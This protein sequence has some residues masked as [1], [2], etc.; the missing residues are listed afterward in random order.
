MR[1]EEEG[2]RARG[3][4]NRERECVCASVRV[5]RECESESIVRKSERGERR[6]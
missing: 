1:D 3:V 6:G 5:Y 4:S 2:T